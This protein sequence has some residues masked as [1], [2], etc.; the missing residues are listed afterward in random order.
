MLSCA[1]LRAGLITARQCDEHRPLCDNCAKLNRNSD[2]ESCKFDVDEPCAPTLSRRADVVSRNTNQGSQP[3]D[4]TTS[5]NLEDGVSSLASSETQFIPIPEPMSILLQDFSLDNLLEYSLAESSSD[6]DTPSPSISELDLFQQYTSFT[7]Q[8]MPFQYDA[9]I[10]RMWTSD[11]PG[12]ALRSKVVLEA[13]L[14][15][16]ALQLSTTDSQIASTFLHYYGQSLGKLRQETTKI[17][18][19]NAEE[20]A[21]T[22]ALLK[23]Q[24]WS[25][26]LH[27]HDSCQSPNPLPET[28]TISNELDRAVSDTR[29]LVSD[30]NVSFYCDK[31][32]SQELTRLFAPD[33]GN[34]LHTRQRYQDLGALLAGIEGAASIPGKIGHTNSHA[35]TYNECISQ[36]VAIHSALYTTGSSEDLRQQVIFLTTH[37]QPNLLALVKEKEQPALA[38][39]AHVMALW[40]FVGGVWWLDGVAKYEVECIVKMMEPESRWM[41]D[42]PLSTTTEHI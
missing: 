5:S 12:L 42:W 8:S 39:L 26:H 32:L 14:G 18:E 2:I 41:M 24:L 9:N 3:S 35:V 22:A 33:S 28:F 15:A 29:P 27:R 34:E 40:K 25:A 38:I 17:N 19:A 36:I 11:A 7:H 6:A 4:G 16:A 30:C 37:L 31:Q 23:V 13:L 20:I 10:A 21:V 1:G